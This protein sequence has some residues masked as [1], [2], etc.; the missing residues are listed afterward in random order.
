MYRLE[1]ILKSKGLTKQDLAERM[2]I[3]RQTLYNMKNPTLSNLEKMADAIGV[4]LGILLGVDL[5]GRIIEICGI[6]YKLTRIAN[7]KV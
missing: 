6:K 4:P 2:G 1:E 7:D 5:D 3:K